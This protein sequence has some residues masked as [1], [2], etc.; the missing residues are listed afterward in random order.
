M[1]NWLENKE[2]LLV[3][4]HKCG[5]E[6]VFA[7]AGESSVVGNKHGVGVA[8]KYKDEGWTFEYAFLQVGEVVLHVRWIEVPGAR[9]KERHNIKSVRG[10]KVI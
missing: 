7:I 6:V 5:R 2:L 1:V 10:R 9:L 8:A 3:W 4:E